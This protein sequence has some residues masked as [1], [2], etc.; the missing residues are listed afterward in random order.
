MNE[1]SRNDA[2]HFI[3]QSASHKPIPEVASRYKKKKVKSI[4]LKLIGLMPKNTYF[5]Y[6]YDRQQCLLSF[7]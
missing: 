3:V 2:L 4:G 6:F 5:L 1:S 7:P